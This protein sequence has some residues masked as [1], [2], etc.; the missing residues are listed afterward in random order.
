MEPAAAPFCL[1]A[2]LNSSEETHK[3][4]PQLPKPCIKGCAV[5]IRISDDEYQK[6]LL[7]CQNNL[8]GRLILPKGTTPAKVTEVRDK[9]FKLWSP[10][11]QWKIIPLGRGFYEFCLASA[12]DL[13]SISALGTCVF[14]SGDKAPV[15]DNT[16]PIPSKD[17]NTS[18]APIADLASP[19]VM[20][21]VAMEPPSD[22][23]HVAQFQPV[24]G[25]NLAENIIPLSQP[26]DQLNSPSHD[27][28]EI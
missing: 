12:E 25:T 6:G 20:T 8:H 19:I 21:E 1:W 4:A 17:P 7:S 28:V 14:T 15:D 9:L 18:S 3:L 13:R 16:V 24:R 26:L 2:F 23:A 22:V 5:S 10:I 27:L 11:G